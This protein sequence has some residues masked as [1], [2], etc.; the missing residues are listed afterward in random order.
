[1]GV[2]SLK[3]SNIYKKRDL[4]RIRQ[5]SQPKPRIVFEELVGLGSYNP[6]DLYFSTK[7]KSPNPFMCKSFNYKFSKVLPISIFSRKPV[8]CE[9]SAIICIL[10]TLQR[11]R[12]KQLVQS[13]TC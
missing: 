12:L 6:I 1:M 8:D 9:R 13:E 5:L 7:Y 10:V 4:S 11:F 3:G 2:Y